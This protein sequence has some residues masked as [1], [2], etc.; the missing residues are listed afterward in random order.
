MHEENL[1]FLTQSVSFFAIYGGGV[2]EL[3]IE[4]GMDYIHQGKKRRKTFPNNKSNRVIGL[5]LHP[6]LIVLILLIVSSS[7]SHL[8]MFST[9]THFDTSKIY[10]LVYV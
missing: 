7:L 3:N 6:L 9:D 10:L 4:G 8:L 1:V 2:C 5:D